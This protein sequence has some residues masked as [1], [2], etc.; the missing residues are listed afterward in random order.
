MNSTIEYIRQLNQAS[1]HLQADWLERLQQV[2]VGPE[3]AVATPKIVLTSESEIKKFSE[4]EFT[5]P[6]TVVKRASSQE[7][8]AH[9]PT[10]PIAP[11]VVR[12]MNQPLGVAPEVAES[13]VDIVSGVQPDTAEVYRSLT[14]APTTDSG[15]DSQTI[16]TQY[17]TS[18]PNVASQVPTAPTPADP[19]AGQIKSPTHTPIANLES[20]AILNDIVQPTIMPLRQS[21]GT[22]VIHPGTTDRFNLPNSG[23]ATTPAPAP[24]PVEP[25][26]KPVAPIAVA[27][28]PVATEVAPETQPEIEPVVHAIK[29]VQVQKAVEAPTVETPTEP[30]APIEPTIADSTTE[31]PIEKT[32]LEMLTDFGLKGDEVFNTDTLTR[33]Q[34]AGLVAAA[35]TE[36][37]S[38]AAQDAG[39]TAE[40]AACESKAAETCDS[41]EAESCEADAPEACDMQTPDTCDIQAP[42]ICNIQTPETSDA[43]ETET[44]CKFPT[45]KRA[46]RFSYEKTK[47][48]KL[49]DSIVDQI[50]ERFPA[51]T[52]P[53][54]MVIGAHREIDVDSGTSRIATCMAGRE[55]GDILMVD[56]NLESRQLTSMLALTKQKGISDAFHEDLDATEMLVHTD[57]PRL[58]IVGAGTL[59]GPDA[60]TVLS[61]ATNT[62]RSLKERFDYTI[63]SGG[64][65]GDPLTDQWSKIVDG[66]YLMVDM[67]E[68]DRNRTVE[69][70]EYFRNLGARIVGC[71]ATRA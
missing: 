63:V 24:A 48:Q 53:V 43:Q 46:E 15:L 7:T 29:T 19:Y 25:V 40:S 47:R 20:P 52:K 34:V 8:I 64:I 22:D 59:V 66:V 38:C 4:G 65:A 41:E 18:T 45:D 28:T 27:P 17:N 50:V 12:A 32:K 23:P 14:G 33:E 37:L 44:Q 67:D 10:Q 68:S 2:E 30:P 5:P 42:E 70:V 54:I 69:T 55:I 71:I 36:S 61:A 11:P 39:C 62:N 49:V 56:G 26:R 9:P 21:R 3:S 57:N 13:T 60:K 51:D 6:V 1:V 35:Q 31:Q 16:E 58:K